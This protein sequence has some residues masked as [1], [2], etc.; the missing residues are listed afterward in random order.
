[1]F[2]EEARFRAEARA[3]VKG[4]TEERDMFRENMELQESQ[5]GN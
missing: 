4:L 5:H 2:K 3:A 1:M